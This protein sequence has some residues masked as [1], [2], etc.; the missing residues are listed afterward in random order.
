MPG[1]TEGNVSEEE[2]IDYT[3]ESKERRKKK[4]DVD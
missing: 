4:Q 3:A 1:D 2:V